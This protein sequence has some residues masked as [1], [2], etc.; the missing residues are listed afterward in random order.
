[1]D[2]YYKQGMGYKAVAKA[3]QVKGHI[4]IRTW[5]KT[6]EQHGVIE[7]GRSRP[8]RRKVISPTPVDLEAEN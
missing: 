4:Y 3:L 7:L 6:Y 2:M 1:M 8:R 5:V